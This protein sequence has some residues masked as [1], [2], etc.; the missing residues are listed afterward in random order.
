MGGALASAVAYA[1]VAAATERPFFGVPI[2]ALA[3]FLAWAIS[4]ELD[5]DRPKVASWS[6]ALAFGALVY[7]LPSAAAAAVALIAVRVIAGTVGKQITWV[8]VV[9]LAV[10][11]VAA[12]SN[13]VIWLPGLAIGMWLASSPEVGDL[14]YFGLAALVAGGGVSAWFAGPSSVEITQEAYI[15]AAV[16]AAAMLFAMTPRTVVAMTDS[17]SGPVDAS[18]VALARRAAGS[19]LMWGAVMGGVAGFWMVSP[20]LAALIATGYAKWFSPGA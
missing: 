1:A 9:A 7:E 16:G 10:F 3:V 2:A 8:D 12:G 15:L 4:R 18:R 13:P 20:I 5:P 19:F 11:G 6:M 14:R 17:R